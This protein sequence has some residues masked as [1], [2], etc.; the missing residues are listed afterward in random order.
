[1]QAGARFSLIAENVA[2]GP[3]PQHLQRS[4]DEFPAA[5]REIFWTA[6]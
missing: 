1:M 2:E 5:P 3:S 6:S 4:V